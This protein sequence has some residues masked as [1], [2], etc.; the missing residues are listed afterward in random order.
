MKKAFALVINLVLAFGL[1]GCGNNES[2]NESAKSENSQSVKQESVETQNSTKNLSQGALEF[3]QNYPFEAY[4]NTTFKQMLEKWT[5]MCA[6]ISWEVSPLDKDKEGIE[7]TANYAEYMAR[8]QGQEL[9]LKVREPF[10]I[11]AYCEIKDFD[12][13]KQR[14]QTYFANDGYVDFD[15]SF[16]G[17]KDDSTSGEPLYLPNVGGSLSVISE[18]VDKLLPGGRELLK[19]LNDNQSKRIFDY[20]MNALHLPLSQAINQS[21][22][23]FLT[24]PFVVI[25]DE[26]EYNGKLEQTY[27]FGGDDDYSNNVMGIIANKSQLKAAALDTIK[28]S[29]QI[30][31]NKFY[32]PNPYNAIDRTSEMYKNA[33]D[34]VKAMFFNQ[35]ISSSTLIEKNFILPKRSRDG[36]YGWLF[37][38]V[39]I[40]SL[41]PTGDW[42]KLT[43][44]IADK[45]CS[46]LLAPPASKKML[47]NVKEIAEFEKNLADFIIKVYSEPNVAPQSNDTLAQSTTNSNQNSAT[48]SPATSTNASDNLPSLKLATKD[49]YVNLRKAP[50]GEILTPIYK[51]DFDKITIKKLDGGNAKWLKVLYFPPSVTDENKA[52]TGYIHISQI[53]K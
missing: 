39:W 10:L 2:K 13:L 32:V 17:K 42:I 11:V 5:N 47:Y 52:I 18:N 45:K 20:V 26:A 35:N 29:F 22:K 38:D 4:Q 41:C 25:Y 27:S 12:T 34:I 24:F 14:L 15:F 46:S 48:P 23:I 28:L 37:N 43:T 53:A 49:D 44:K 36:D 19:E 33:I 40:E 16:M 21:E 30:Q 1:V 7:R 50:S 8:R 31:S 51:K 6:S 9:E 3:V